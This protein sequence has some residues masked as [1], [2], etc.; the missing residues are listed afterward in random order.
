MFYR[1]KQLCF[2]RVRQSLPLLS[3]VAHL[4]ADLPDIFWREKR[5]APRFRPSELS[6]RVADP[7]LS[8]SPSPRVVVALA[9]SAN[10][11]HTSRPISRQISRTFFG[12]KTVELHVSDPFPTS[13][14]R[15]RSE[16][17]VRQ[18]WWPLP[19]RLTPCTFPGPYPDRSPGYFLAGKS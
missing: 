7:S 13:L 6:R 3:P 12:G 2:W 8:R 16:R 11:L 14:L 19:T 1:R 9:D 4:P 17:R 15:A 18:S 5:R 10:T